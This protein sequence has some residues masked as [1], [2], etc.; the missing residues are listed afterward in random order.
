MARYDISALMGMRPN[1]RID[2]N[3]FSEVGSNLLRQ[4]STSVLSEQPTN[5]SRNVSNFSRQSERNTAA[6]EAAS[7]STTRQ[8]S[9]PPCGHRAQDD[10][11]FA[12][13][14]KEHTSPKHQRVTAGGRIVPMEAPPK[15]KLP[16]FVPQ[17]KVSGDKK[18]SVTST[19]E[20][21]SNKIEQG[22]VRAKDTLLGIETSKHGSQSAGVPINYAF[23]AYGSFDPYSQS[24]GQTPNLLSA[25]GASGLMS[26]LGV[27]WPPDSQQL[28][29][30]ELQSPEYHIPAAPEYSMLNFTNPC[31]WHPSL[32]D[33]LNT[34]SALTP[35]MPPIQPHATISTPSDFSAGSIASS[36]GATPL[37]S[38]FYSGYGMPYTPA[39]LQWH[40][41]I[42]GQAPV[43]AQPIMPAVM[44][45][46][47][48]QKSLDDAAKEYDNLSAQLSRLDR[49]MAMHTWDLDPQTKKLLVEQRVGLVKE[50]DTVRI[51]R[52]HLEWASA[53]IR[54][55][56]LSTH[57]GMSEPALSTGMYLAG[58]LANSQALFGQAA[59]NSSSESAVP[60]FAM[61]SVTGA[62]PSQLSS[63]ESGSSTA[64]PSMPWQ[65]STDYFG[66]YQVPALQEANTSIKAP[67]QSQR[68]KSKRPIAIKVPPVEPKKDIASDRKVKVAKDSEADWTSRN[69]DLPSNVLQV[70]RQ[71]EEIARQG[72]S[73]SGLLQD[74]DSAGPT[75]K[76]TSDCYYPPKL[77]A[78]RA[79][80]ERIMGTQ[81][82]G[83]A[84]TVKLKSADHSGQEFSRLRSSRDPRKPRNR[85]RSHEDVVKSPFVVVEEDDARSILSY[86]ST[87]DSWATVHEKDFGKKELGCQKST[88][89]R[90]L[91]HEST[92]SVKRPT[93]PFFD[94]P[95]TMTKHALISGN[96]GIC[97]PRAAHRRSGPALT[98]DPIPSRQ[99]SNAESMKLPCSPLLASYLIKDRSLAG[100]KTMALA[101]P[102]N[103]HAHGI[104]PHIDR[105][106]DVT[107]KCRA[108]PMTGH[109][110]GT[111]WYKPERGVGT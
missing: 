18:G 78:T 5:R 7:R 49:Y 6:P 33:A 35:F 15:M 96:G 13:F 64:I 103:V 46:P 104:V 84:G 90:G 24:L 61:P 54:M 23:P 48:Y 55:N 40:Q 53:K 25:A 68:L 51:Y 80:G 22:N 108:A 27:P 12:R 82:I 66:P 111:M 83:N 67:T 36:G 77:P 34:P 69:K 88:L 41:L 110:I 71:I 109:G 65:S 101:V 92:D 2:V 57:V 44:P 21:E 105:I 91:S 98:D 1:A 50:L 70:Y 47:L 95:N 79:T 85:P 99:R 62:F 39:G 10:S 32:Y 17:H 20:N 43:Q 14:L 3:R 37:L 16:T 11:G 8:P 60:T 102:Q 38:P 19:E 59:C 63:N 42:N 94:I 9:D 86:V 72:D 75:I 30:S 31:V 73:L 28:L 106:G 29:E 52:E 45:T 58:N 81:P 87:T 4:H 93:T 97:S 74:L 56:A 100:Q 26:Q 89:R 107:R 76:P